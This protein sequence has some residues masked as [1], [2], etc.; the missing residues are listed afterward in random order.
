MPPA[1]QRQ[2]G[3]NG[4]DTGLLGQYL[5]AVQNAVTQNWLRPDNMPSVPCQVHITQI[6]GG[7]VLD[8]KVDPSC[9]YDEAGRRSVEN[10]VL[11]AQPLPYKGFESVFQRNLTFTFRPQ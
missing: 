6:V 2:T 1:A 3:T 10:A 8:A 7:Q 11:R 4:R 9:P 5:A